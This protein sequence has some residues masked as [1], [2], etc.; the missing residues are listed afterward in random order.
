M[1]EIKGH[2]RPLDRCAQPKYNSAAAPLAAPPLA[3]PKSNGAHAVRATPWRHVRM[4]APVHVAHAVHA[5]G[6]RTMGAHGR[7]LGLC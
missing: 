6:H 4:H 1:S 5:R 3:G 7:R 2:T